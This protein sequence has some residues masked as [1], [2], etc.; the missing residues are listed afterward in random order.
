MRLVDAERFAIA[1]AFVFSREACG[2]RN[3]A[4]SCCARCTLN[5]EKRS[6]EPTPTATASQIRLVTADN[7]GIRTTDVL[8]ALR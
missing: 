7:G 8:R 2:D 6:P 1:D 5:I 3:A 4:S